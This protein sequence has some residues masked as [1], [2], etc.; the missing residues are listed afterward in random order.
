MTPINDWSA[1]RIVVSAPEQ[2]LCISFPC[3]LD[4]YEVRRLGS[5]PGW[6]AV[7]E[8]PTAEAVLQVTPS[9]HCPRCGGELVPV[10]TPAAPLHRRAG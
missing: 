1:R 8:S 7:A 9:P 5:D 2:R 4:Q 6:W 3:L 10:P